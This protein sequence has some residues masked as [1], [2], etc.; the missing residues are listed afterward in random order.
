MG[1]PDTANCVARQAPGLPGKRLRIGAGS[2][3]VPSL[4][5]AAMEP[6]LE[7]RLHRDTT[8]EHEEVRELA[9]A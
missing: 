4:S 2:L 9:A 5:A 6:P 3:F 1:A 8:P 7:K